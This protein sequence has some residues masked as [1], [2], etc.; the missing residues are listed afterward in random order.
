MKW[1]KG[2]QPPKNGYYLATLE[3]DDNYMKTP[4]RYV[5][6]LEYHIHMG[7]KFRG[8]SLNSEVSVKAWAKPKPYKEDV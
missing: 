8:L 4:T 3:D 6:I 2:N 5:E 1:T 7:W